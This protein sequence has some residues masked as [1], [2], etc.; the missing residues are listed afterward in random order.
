MPSTQHACSFKTYAVSVSKAKPTLHDAELRAAH[1][2]A[3]AT[4]IVPTPADLG[5][6]ATLIGET[7]IT[8]LARST[9]PKAA[10]ADQH[11]EVIPRNGFLCWAPVEG[12]AS[13]LL[14]DASGRLHLMQLLP[15]GRGRVGGVQVHALGA[16]TYASCMAYLDTGVVFIGSRVGNSQLLR[17]AET[18]QGPDQTFTQVRPKQVCVQAHCLLH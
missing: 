9:D 10:V 1:V 14:A 4:F 15:A 6:G 8:H 16:A 11:R 17:L 13:T 2:D 3:G 12:N 18:P 7:S 5:G